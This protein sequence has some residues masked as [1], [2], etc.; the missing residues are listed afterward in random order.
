[1][2]PSRLLLGGSG[3]EL[4]ARVQS[5]FAA[6]PTRTRRGTAAGSTGFTVPAPPGDLGASIREVS[7]TSLRTY[8]GDPVRF[9]LERHER[10]SAVNPRMAELDA[11][12]FGTL[13][14]DV[15]DAAFADAAVRAST[16]VA[17]VRGAFLSALDRLVLARLGPRLRPALRMQIRSMRTRLERL[18][19]I[20][21]ASRQDGWLIHDIERSLPE[22]CTLES[23]D[24]VPVRITG[25]M[26]RIERRDSPDGPEYRVLDAK[27][28]EE[29]KSPREAHFGGPKSAPAWVDLQLP[30]YRHFAAAIVGADPTRVLTGYLQL[31]ADP[32]KVA[33]ELADF[34]PI[35][36]ASAIAKAIETI[37][38]IRAGSF[39]PGSVGGRGPNR[40][41][42]PFRFILQTPVFAGGDGEEDA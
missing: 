4:A 16:D 38:L 6:P 8:L 21:V 42:D 5:L 27:T 24:G 40:D 19:A 41:D 30:L 31:P 28:S 33:I 35:E 34:T 13:V 11:T 36:H 3:R 20:E 9:W 29:A 32:R 26:D 25:R 18:A 23:P 12:T 2:L 39:A 7:V 17:E 15:L 22:S 10:I 1:M 37:G 14:H